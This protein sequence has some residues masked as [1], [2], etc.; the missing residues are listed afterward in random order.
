M[1]DF[2]HAFIFSPGDW[3]GEGNIALQLVEEQLLFN[4]HWNIPT[5]DPAGKVQCLQNIHIQ[6]LSENMSNCLTF[7]NFQ[8]K[9]FCVDIENQN[10]G[11]VSGSGVYDDNLIGWEF[12]NHEKDF[13]GF[14]TYCL[15]ED[16][17]Y[18]MHGEYVTTD[19]FRT[20]IKARISPRV[21]SE[22]GGLP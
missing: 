10:I 17:S 8:N 20:Q 14:E 12:C 2:M 6:G 21:R 15:Q 13:E 22:T 1:D 16:G 9:S 3:E 4:T 19:Q 18:L 7:Y 11:K 5:R